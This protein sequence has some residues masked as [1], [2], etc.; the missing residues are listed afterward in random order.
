LEGVEEEDKDV[1]RAQLIEQKSLEVKFSIG[2]IEVEL[3]QTTDEGS[4]LIIAK[5]LL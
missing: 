5:V 1:V 4:N 3:C 2:S